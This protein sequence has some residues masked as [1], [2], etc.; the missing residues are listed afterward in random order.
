MCLRVRASSL[1]GTR[2]SLTRQSSNTGWHSAP[3]KRQRTC[4][5]TRK[6]SVV[7]RVT[8]ENVPEPRQP[9][10]PRARTCAHDTAGG[11][12]GNPS[13]SPQA[14]THRLAAI[15]FLNWR[16]PADAGVADDADAV[17][18]AARARCAGNRAGGKGRG[19]GGGRPHRQSDGACGCRRVDVVPGCTPRARQPHRDP[20]ICAV[21]STGMRAHARATAG[22]RRIVPSGRCG[23]RDACQ[24]GRAQL[25]VPTPHP[26]T[27]SANKRSLRAER[28]THSGSACQRAW[29]SW[30]GWVACGRWRATQAHTHTPCMTTPPGLMP[31][32]RLHSGG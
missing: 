31:L 28:P 24:R 18:R 4:E 23:H 27:P 14:G 20:V 17:R 2:R 25:P 12:E 13:Q 19:W 16:W 6:W 11:Y 32:D 15:S 26:P 22:R 3:P 9:A 29:Y 5:R 30:R 10:S 8:G 21:L 7:A 1:G